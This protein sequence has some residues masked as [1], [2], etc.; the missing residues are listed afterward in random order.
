[1]PTRECNYIDDETGFKCMKPFTVPSH[2]YK[3]YRCDEHDLNKSPRRN[4]QAASQRL[5][6]TKQEL[7]AYVYDLKD[8]IIPDITNRLLEAIHERDE[9]KK[10]IENYELPSLESIIA[11]SPELKLNINTYQGQVDTFYDGMN[12]L[13]TAHMKKVKEQH[14]HTISD[15]RALKNEIE[16]MINGKLD[17]FTLETEVTKRMA[18]QILTLHTRNIEYE[19][20][21]Q[22]LESKE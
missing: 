3:R 18:E 8:E 9:L 22:Q 4:R 1:M 11:N 15:F 2:N 16:T 14:T 5:R 19:K 12:D 13:H 21:I 17:S 7:R 20:R 10:L 6:V